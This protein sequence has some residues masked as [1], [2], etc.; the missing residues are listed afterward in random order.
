MDKRYL[1]K[2]LCFAV[3]RLH[4]QFLAFETGRPW[5]PCCV[6]PYANYS[7]RMQQADADSRIKTLAAVWIRVPPQA[8]F[9]EVNDE[10]HVKSLKW[11]PC[12]RAHG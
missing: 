10:A 9:F 7:C 11:S 5:L 12:R 8:K 2:V 4:F 1:P 6:V 3:S